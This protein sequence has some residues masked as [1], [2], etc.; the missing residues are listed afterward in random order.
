MIVKTDNYKDLGINV[1]SKAR[2]LFQLIELGYNV[3][4][5][6]VI[7]ANSSIDGSVLNNEIKNFGNN[8]R[9]AVRSSANVEDS[10]QFSF[11]GVFETYLGVEAE[12]VFEKVSL[13]GDIAGNQKLASYCEYNCLDINDVK[14]SIII[15]EMVEADFSGVAF[16][17][18]PVD[19]NNEQIFIE[20]VEGLGESL[21]SGESTPTT[22]VLD[23]SNVGEGKGWEKALATKIIELEQVYGHPVDVEWSYALDKLYIL[24]VRPVTVF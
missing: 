23:K 19:G 2:N 1:G 7:Q 11:A 5:F 18:N 4:R 3:P 21:V 20:S 9:F 16:S 17:I 22:V 10:S 6:F 24:Q 14:V 13:C 8:T 15:Q 12:D